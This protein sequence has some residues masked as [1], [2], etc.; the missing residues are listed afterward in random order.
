[1]PFVAVAEQWIQDGKSCVYSLARFGLC[2]PITGAEVLVSITALEFSYTQAP[3]SM[4]SFIMGLFLLSVSLGNV[5]VS[6]S[7]LVYS[8]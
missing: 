8:K 1:M 7:E 6:A 4:K 3:N 5:F 2:D